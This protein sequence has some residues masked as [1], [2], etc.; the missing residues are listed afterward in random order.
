MT[1][2]TV[3][4]SAISLEFK[5]NVQLSS[6]CLHMDILPVLPVFPVYPVEEKKIL[7][8]FFSPKPF[9]P[10]FSVFVNECMTAH[11]VDVCACA[12]VF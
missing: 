10:C 8:F 4:N 7:I 11:G 1:L 3:P 6:G 9:P 5:T 12:C 2:K